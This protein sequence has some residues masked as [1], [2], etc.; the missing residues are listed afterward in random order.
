MWRETIKAAKAAQGVSSK[1][2]S[3]RTGGHLPERT[4]ARILSGE[5]EFPRIDTII[6]MGEA[7]GLSAQEIFAEANVTVTDVNVDALK[8]ENDILLAERDEAIAKVAVLQATVDELKIKVDTLKDEI[9]DTHKY[10]IK[11]GQG[12]QE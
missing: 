2:M 8:A 6:E 3:E 11:K 7:V 10:Y 9:I 5:T 4:I 1:T 12:K